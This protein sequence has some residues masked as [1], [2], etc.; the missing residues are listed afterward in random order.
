MA[1]VFD[2]GIDVVGVGKTS[3]EKR[4]KFRGAGLY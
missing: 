4:A 3:G 2:A 1:E